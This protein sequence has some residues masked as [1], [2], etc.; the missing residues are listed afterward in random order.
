MRTLRLG[1]EFE[2]DL[3]AYS[4]RRDGR[5]VRLERLPMEILIFLVQR[6][7]ELVTREEIA[8]KMWGTGVFQDTDN[9]LNVAIRKVRQ[10][11]R[12]DS[13]SPRFIRTVTAKGYRFIAPV[14]E[15]VAAGAVLPP[16]ETPSAPLPDVA[17]TREE[18]PRPGPAPA[19]A[20][21]ASRASGKRSPWLWALATAGLVVVTTTAFVFRSAHSSPAAAPSDK[22][23]MLAVLPFENLT[24][25]PA[26]E[27]F[28]DG[29]TEEMIT[30]LGSIA[31]RRL[32]VIAR[33]SVMPYKQQPS[34]LDR[35]GRE[36]GVRYVVEGSVRRDAD[37]V[38]ITA[39]LIRVSD[40]AH[41]WAHEY[42]RERGD[43]LRVQQ[44]IARAIA[45]Q[46][47]D[48]LGDPR[49]SAPTAAALPPRE[50]EAY[51]NY[52]KGRSFWNQRNLDGFEKAIALFQKSIAGNP[53]DAR[54]FAGLADT[55]ALMGTYGYRP[56]SEVVPRARAAALS[57]LALD[58]GLSEAH[59]SLA[60]LDEFYDWDWPAAEAAFR[61]AIAL[62]PNSVT[63]HHWYA[64][65]LAFQGRFDEA[66]DEIDE[67]RRLDPLSRIVAAD[68]GA[69]LYD[70]RQYDRAIA[71]FRDVLASEP[72]FGRA[73]LIA[74]VYLMQGEY[75][76]A[77]RHL[78]DWEAMEDGPWTHAYLAYTY[79]RLGRSDEARRE[80]E[81]IDRVN[82]DAVA[83]VMPRVV[84]QVGMGLHEEALAS[85][86]QLCAERSTLLISLKVDPVYDPLRDDPKFQ[87]LLRCV[88]L[89]P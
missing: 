18:V 36:L 53:H 21:P 62:D 20:A 67:A 72:N 3:R 22:R 66:L 8:A 64:E 70:A 71:V 25:D 45:G 69:I 79:G 49:S 59:T 68:K 46:I 41:L 2:L 65:F 37:R 75:E 86:R 13:E 88:H 29:F 11:L 31:P 44:E 28:S 47:E 60:L 1:G 83:V 42:D 26:Q 50:Y 27:Y 63:G 77:L 61:K 74:V 39:R 23:I 4:L 17:A 51:E 54:S 7:P 48:T 56:Q 43:L 35:L 30:T 5:E 12:D 16:Q 55:W 33:T 9:S 14:E 80:M 87:D 38:S 76:S 40:Q 85:L 32:G 19:P 57:A 34:P 15:D 6:R 78:R 58:P 84:A 81:M 82:P 52:L 24:G 10:A 73:H 89:I